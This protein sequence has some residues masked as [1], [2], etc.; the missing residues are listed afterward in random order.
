MRDFYQKKIDDCGNDQN[1]LFR[2]IEELMYAV[3]KAVPPTHSDAEVLADQFA[4]FFDNTMMTEMV[5]ED[6]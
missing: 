5:E 6:P 4:D 2:I 1:K 3:K